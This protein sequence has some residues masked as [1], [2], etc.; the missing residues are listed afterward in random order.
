M[1]DM[2]PLVIDVGELKEEGFQGCEE[3]RGGGVI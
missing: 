2:E 3:E 1:L